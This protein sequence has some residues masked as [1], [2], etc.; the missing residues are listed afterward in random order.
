MTAHAS[1]AKA[2]RSPALTTFE[3]VAHSPWLNL[4]A[5]SIL[6]TTGGLETI[7]LALDL[8][9]SDYIGAHHGVAAYGLVHVLK[10]FP[11]LFKGIKFVEEGEE[12][13]TTLVGMGS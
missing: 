5:G 10:S 11:D 3:K 6:L 1:N 7:D 2:T 8:G 9:I 12:A 13:A 4:L